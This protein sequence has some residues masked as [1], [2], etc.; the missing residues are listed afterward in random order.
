LALI[1]DV[2]AGPRLRLEP[3]ERELR[4]QTAARV[5]RD[6]R[7][8]AGDVRVD[9]RLRPVGQRV[10]GVP[11]GP[12]EP[13]GPQ[14]PVLRQRHLAEDLGQPSESGAAL[15]LHL[16]QAILGVHVPESEQRVAEETRPAPMFP[17]HATPPPAYRS[18]TAPETVSAPL[19]QRPP[20]RLA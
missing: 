19:F 3:Q 2:G 13:D 8:D 11:G 6:E 7:V 20:P 14:E 12:A 5:R 17:R 16:P 15:E 1:D 9:L 4:R 18:R 10:P